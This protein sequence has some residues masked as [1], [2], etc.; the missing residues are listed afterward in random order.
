[1]LKPSDHHIHHWVTKYFLLCKGEIDNTLS[2]VSMT[3]FDYIVKLF[4]VYIK[5]SS[6]GCVFKSTIYNYYMVKACLK[7][8]ALFIYSEASIFKDSLR[9]GFNTHTLVV[10]ICF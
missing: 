10:N 4:T 6:T 8:V 7:T 5:S 9:T 3:A 1:M 2:V